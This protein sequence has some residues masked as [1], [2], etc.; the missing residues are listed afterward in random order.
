M[1]FETEEVLSTLPLGSLEVV[2]DGKYE[3]WYHYHDGKLDYIKKSNRTLAEK[4]A[5]KR[6][7]SDTLT[8][9]TAEKES[10]E[11]YFQKY[12]S[13][14]NQREKSRKNSEAYFKLLSDY[15]QVE[16]VFE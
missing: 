13:M 1:I 9:L 15:L 4:L 10:L 2:T 11:T 7:L 12:D 16:E 5:Y 6:Y 3:K 8:N 14:H